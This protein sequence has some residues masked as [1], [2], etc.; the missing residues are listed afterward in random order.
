MLLIA[1]SIVFLLLDL[2]A[3]EIPEQVFQSKLNSKTPRVIYA[4]GKIN[5]ALENFNFTA[6]FEAKIVEED[7]AVLSLY[8]PMNVL[9]GKAYS[10]RE[11]FIYYDILGNWAAIGI[12]TAE[13]VF[14]AAQIPLGFVD[15]VRLFKAE[16]LYPND[17]L[18][19]S[20]LE[21]GKTLLTYKSQSFVDF[22]LFDQDNKLVQYQKKNL[23]GKI[24]I[25]IT[26]PE[27]LSIE[28]FTFPKKYVLLV[29]ARKGYISIETEKVI[30]DFDMSKPFSFQVP[31]SVEIFRYE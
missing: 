25:N 8:G 7:S 2:K 3:Q 9:V 11:R 28:N 29:E 5:F 22:F 1:I 14:E 21:N 10:N 26:Y 31:K 27:F 12:P 15:L 4:K 6:Q 17:S 16:L 30:L 23:E 18:K 13:K 19:Y 24:V 20:L